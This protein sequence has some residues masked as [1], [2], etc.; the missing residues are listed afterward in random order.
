MKFTRCIIILITLTLAISTFANAEERRRIRK[1]KLPSGQNSLSTT[2]EQN[3][4]TEDTDEGNIMY[5]DRHNV[6]CKP[7]EALSYF[8]LITNK[9]KIEEVHYASKCLKSGSINVH[10]KTIKE[11]L[12]KPGETSKHKESLIY[13]DRH[14]VKCS[15]GSVLSSFQLTR[16]SSNR[17][18]IRY[19]F[20]CVPAEILCCKDL[21][22]EKVSLEGRQI[23]YLDRLEVDSKLENSAIQR[24]KLGTT[25][26]EG[27]EKNDR[28]WYDYTICKLKDMAVVSLVSNLEADAKINAENIQNLKEHLDKADEDS[29]K[30]QN[31]LQEYEKD[32]QNVE[33]QIAENTISEASAQQLIDKAK[34]KE[35]KGEIE[36]EEF[37]N[38]CS[39]LS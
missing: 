21:S 16:N 23:Y 33:N 29:I 6:S 26:K 12:T 39:E 28:I 10:N 30:D 15:S 18:E 27:N 13:L 11:E 17:E 1:N 24:F 32:L 9:K 31:K 37:K 3:T 25:L 2:R 14:D 38:N 36:I 19:K 35:A 34:E 5:L 8:K 20:K 22:T 7:D 4:K